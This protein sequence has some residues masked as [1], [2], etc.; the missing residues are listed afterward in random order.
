M[1]RACGREGSVVSY[2]SSIFLI[3][4]HWER[5]QLSPNRVF[6]RLEDTYDEV[7]SM[8]Y[9]FPQLSRSYQYFQK[10]VF[11]LSNGIWLK[12]CWLSNILFIASEVGSGFVV[13]GKFR[14]REFGFPPRTRACFTIENDHQL[15]IQ[16]TFQ[17]L[18]GVRDGCKT[19]RGREAVHVCH[20]LYIC[21][22]IVYNPSSR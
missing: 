12:L 20:N 21:K 9:R 5:L 7:L 6:R 22:R 17:I 13:Q 4:E 18:N 14:F 10:L 3:L 8:H 15:T 19:V 2:R 1:R 11:G 16:L